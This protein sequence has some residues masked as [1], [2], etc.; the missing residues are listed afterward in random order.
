MIG[1]GTCKKTSEINKKKPTISDQS[2]SINK[3][4]IVD[5]TLLS[6]WDN[7]ES[8]VFY[9]NLDYNS[10]ESLIEGP[11]F[12]SEIIYDGKLKNN[13]SRNPDN[14]ASRG[15]ASTNRTGVECWT[16]SDRRASPCDYL[17]MLI[18]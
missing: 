1:L 13:S 10:S 12:K 16:Y 7:I 3:D 4:R 8:G 18:L 15:E 9:K 5:S 14:L 6:K 17:T 11:F 2:S